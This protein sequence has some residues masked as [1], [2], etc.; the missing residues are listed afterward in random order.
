MELPESPSEKKKFLQKSEFQNS[1]FFVIPKKPKKMSNHI[2]TEILIIVSGIIAVSQ[3]IYA[4][5]EKNET[6]S[7]S[8]GTLQIF[9]I[10]IIGILTGLF[11]QW[12]SEEMFRAASVHDDDT[13]ERASTC[14]YTLSALLFCTLSFTG[15]MISSIFIFLNYKTIT[16]SFQLEGLESLLLS[17]I[18]N[19]GFEIMFVISIVN[20]LF[21]DFA[22][23]YPTHYSQ[24]KEINL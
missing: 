9:S 4:P 12:L 7:F 5:G 2:L 19:T 10:S 21:V 14:R 23:L 18:I 11:G 22:D 8:I 15:L 6:G 1:R 20:F 13:E 17:T 16:T 3:L 24:T